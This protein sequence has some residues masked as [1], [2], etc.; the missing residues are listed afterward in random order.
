MPTRKQ[1]FRVIVIE[2]EE[3][4]EEKRT[5]EKQRTSDV[6]QWVGGLATKIHNLNFVPENIHVGRTELMLQIVG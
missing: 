3:E 1:N 5:N 6:A 4:I 2:E